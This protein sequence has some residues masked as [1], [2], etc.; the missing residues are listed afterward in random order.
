MHPIGRVVPA[1]GRS[2]V[3]GALWVRADLALVIDLPVAQ[4]LGYD[5]APPPAGYDSWAEHNL[6]QAE[7]PGEAWVKIVDPSGSGPTLL[8]H[9]VP[10]PKTVKNRVHLDVKAPGHEPGRHQQV[11]A[12]IATVI[13]CGGTK[14]RDVVD[15]AGYFA[16]MQ[17]PE[18]NEFCIG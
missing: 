7:E 14:V 9:R 17:D 15:D 16:V 10:E 13:A 5:V 3:C 6:A 12:F 18:N 4:V 8:F 2:D 1:V 11:A